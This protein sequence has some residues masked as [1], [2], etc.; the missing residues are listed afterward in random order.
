[1]LYSGFTISALKLYYSVVAGL[2]EEGR[3][4]VN[5][6]DPAAHTFHTFTSIQKMLHEA[7]IIS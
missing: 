2:A 1:M 6:L 5:L 7:G 3:V 4:Y